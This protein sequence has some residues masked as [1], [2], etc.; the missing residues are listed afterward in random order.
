MG[1]NEPTKAWARTRRAL[2]DQMGEVDGVLP[3]SVVTRHMRC[4]VNGHWVLRPGGHEFS[5]LV[6]TGVPGWWP[7]DLGLS[8]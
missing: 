7:P 6:A 4:G 5:G 1:P 3:G 8:V 2:A